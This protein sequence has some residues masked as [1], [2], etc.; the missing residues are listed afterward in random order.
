MEHELTAKIAEAIE[1]ANQ[2]PNS[3]AK[4]LVLTK[5]DESATVGAGSDPGRRPKS[6]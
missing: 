4:S 6:I 1:A 3:R 5:L 2:L